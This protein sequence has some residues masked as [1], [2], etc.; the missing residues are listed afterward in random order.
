MYVLYIRDPMGLISICYN[1]D[2]KT[3]MHEIV[4]N[5]PF[6]NPR[7]WT[8]QNMFVTSNKYQ[9]VANVFCPVHIYG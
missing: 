4:D 7:I 6:K 5:P 2:V 9:K 3:A 1:L 8:G